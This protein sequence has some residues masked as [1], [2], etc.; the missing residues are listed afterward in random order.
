MSHHFYFWEHLKL[1]ITRMIEPY[2][3]SM[4]RYCHAMK[5]ISIHLYSNSMTTLLAM[6]RRLRI[7]QFGIE[8]FWEVLTLLNMILE[9]LNH[10]VRHLLS[11][12]SFSFVLH[13]SNQMLTFALRSLFS[14]LKSNL[15][16]HW[17]EVE[18]SIDEYVGTL[19]AIVFMGC[20]ILI[21]RLESKTTVLFSWPKG[22]GRFKFNRVF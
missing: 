11:H 2:C 7:K 13:E 9:L 19:H 17:I 10:L 20:A 8:C 21:Q 22:H 12:H 1:P 3:W 16:V 4:V 18:T 14:F 5:T 6:I 15:K